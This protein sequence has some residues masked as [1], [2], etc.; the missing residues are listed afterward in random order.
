MARVPYLSESD[1]TDDYRALLARPIN[2]FRCLANSP[3]GFRQFFNIGEWIRFE[4]QLDPRLR[5]LAILQ[6]GYLTSNAYEFSDHV[7]ISRRFGVTDEDIDSLRA[8]HD[9][10]TTSLGEL[11]IAVL[12]AA[13]E[14][15][16]YLSITADTWSRLAKHLTDGRLV[17]LVIVIAF[18]NQVVRVLNS[19]EVSVE[20]DYEAY[21]ERFPLRAASPL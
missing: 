7:E 15:T 4:C 2:L 10:Q 5:E 16:Q 20:P 14:M 9:G 6:V 8:V 13:R 11:E 21:L 12:S 3:G 18:Y 1:L 19:L 17:D